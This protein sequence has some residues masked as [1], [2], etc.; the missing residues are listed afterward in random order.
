[1]EQSTCNTQAAINAGQLLSE[2]RTVGD[3]DHPIVTIPKESQVVD[4]EKHLSIPTRKR[5]NTT[6]V[7]V[8]SFIAFVKAEK[9]GSTRVYGNLENPQFIAVFNDHA[10]GVSAG[11]RDFTAKYA[12]PLAPE[13]KTWNA[14][15]GKQMTQEAFAQF[16]ED[17][18][19][20]IVAPV[21]ADMLE[22]SRSLEAKKKVNFA[23]GI[24]LA[25]GQNQ[26]TYEEEISGTANKGQL[27]VPEIFKIGIP[28]LIG[29]D[30]Y[31]VEARLRYRIADGG[32]LTIWYELVRAHKVI[33]DAIAAV[34]TSI[35]D[36]T[37]LQVLNGTPS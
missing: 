13:W 7:D 2:V 28:V 29:G 37:G 6:L 34:R 30:S 24:R 25:N 8:G 35:E 23:S 15:S 17:N 1:M 11:W 33:E 9:V 3:L 27:L 12:C 19:P 20:D 26:L 16:I 14:S 18:L 4:L 10:D 22:I 31:A 21:G 32:K 5:G 36:G